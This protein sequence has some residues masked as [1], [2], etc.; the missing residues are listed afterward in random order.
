M[1]TEN[2]VCLLRKRTEESAVFNS[3]IKRLME[4]E[5][6]EESD[7]LVMMCIHQRICDE[8]FSLTQKL[9]GEESVKSTEQT[10]QQNN[11]QYNFKSI[12]EVKYK[13]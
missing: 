12:T 10:T 11:Y 5:A 7:L 13:E 2:S 3:A 8:I 4:H 1:N 6:I 9:H